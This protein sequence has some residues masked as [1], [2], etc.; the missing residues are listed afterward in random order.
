M[1]NK[2]IVYK[3]LCFIIKKNPLYLENVSFAFYSLA[4]RDGQLCVQC[5]W[6]EIV[7]KPCQ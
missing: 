7:G 6:Q 2:K 4:A 3:V 5:L 1:E